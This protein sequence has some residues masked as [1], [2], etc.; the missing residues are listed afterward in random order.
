LF[1]IGWTP[2][3]VIDYMAGPPRVM[4]PVLVPAGILPRQLPVVG[5]ATPGTRLLLNDP[6]LPT[7][8]KTTQTGTNHLEHKF[9]LGMYAR[10][11]R[12][13]DQ[14]DL[15][16]SIEQG[17]PMDTMSMME[18]PSKAPRMPMSLEAMPAA[19]VTTP[20]MQNSTLKTQT[21]G[22]GTQDANQKLQDNESEQKVVPT[23]E[24]PEKV[25]KPGKKDKPNKAVKIERQGTPAGSAAKQ[26][27]R[28][29]ACVKSHKRCTHRVQQSPTPQPGPDGSFVTPIAAVNPVPTSGALESHTKAPQPIPD[30]SLALP[31]ENAALPTPLTLEK[32]ATAKRK[33]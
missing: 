26:G 13:F 27:R 22:H 31:N 32:G 4:Q 2:Q 11:H 15:A 33:R 30:H 25:R 17:R 28:C 12:R 5:Q 6:I 24:E 9:E 16:K 10:M 20:M 21:T 19:Q 3:Q 18:T 29:V 8:H 14:G 7:A 1:D 23:I